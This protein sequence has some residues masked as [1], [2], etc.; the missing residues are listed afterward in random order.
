MVYLNN[1]IRFGLV[2]SPVLLFIGFRDWLKK[3]LPLLLFS[4][5]WA[6]AFLAYPKLV[7][8]LNWHEI[9]AD[10]DLG[11]AMSRATGTGF[12]AV[13][14]IILANDYWNKKATYFK[15]I[16]KLSLE[17]GI[18]IFTALFSILY[19]FTG[20]VIL[21]EVPASVS[22]WYKVGIT[23]QIFLICMVYYCFYYI[24]YYFFIISICK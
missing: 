21:D 5:L 16:Q 4:L 3:H 19:A 23:F 13:E 8:V 7:E 6:M 18:M 9:I 10:G 12:L 11:K 20:F 22:F 15:W 14:L 24:N 2:F 1:V 17:K